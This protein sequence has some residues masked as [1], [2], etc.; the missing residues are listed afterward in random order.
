[1]NLGSKYYAKIQMLNPCSIFRSIKILY[2]T[3]I[4]PHKTGPDMKPSGE[5]E[6]RSGEKEER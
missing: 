6:E 3:G 2:Y 4:Q 1:L 5:K